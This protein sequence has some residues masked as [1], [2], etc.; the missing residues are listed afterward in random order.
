MAQTDINV[1]LTKA[2]SLNSDQI[3]MVLRNPSV[4]QPRSVG[5]VLSLK[6]Y[7]TADDLVADL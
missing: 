2:T 3:K 7:A 1:V 6:D 4:S 5:D